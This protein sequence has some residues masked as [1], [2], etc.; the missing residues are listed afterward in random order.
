MYTHT[1]L[2]NGQYLQCTNVGTLSQW[3][4]SLMWI[5]V[6]VLDLRMAFFL[7][8]SWDMES[9]SSGCMWT[10]SLVL[11]PVSWLSALSTCRLRSVWGVEEWNHKKRWNTG[12]TCIYMCTR[13]T[14]VLIQ[15]IYMHAYAHVLCTNSSKVRHMESLKSANFSSKVHV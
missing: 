1:L 10:S 9:E 13:Y 14:N 8:T 15:C 6:P 4:C 12:G 7:Q 3:S 5:W 11:A 2:L